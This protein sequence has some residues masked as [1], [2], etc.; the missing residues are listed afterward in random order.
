MQYFWLSIGG[1]LGLL[2]GK[3][4]WHKD[5]KRIKLQEQIIGH[6]KALSEYLEGKL[7]ETWRKN[8]KL[9]MKNI[10]DTCKEIE[11]AAEEWEAEHKGEDGNGKLH[12]T[13][14][15]NLAQRIR[16]DNGWLDDF[17]NLVRGYYQDNSCGG[18]LYVVLEEGNINDSNVEWSA[19]YTA[20]VEDKRGHDI[21]NL[22]LHMTM[23][24]RNLVL[25]TE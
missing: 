9:M 19:G 8:H 4:L 13:T 12:Y 2:I 10:D 11:K 1:L 18:N 5:H 20:R 21:A 22:M 16:E 3:L 24:Q 17:M 15:N 25:H 6:Y 14:F 23:E 7:N